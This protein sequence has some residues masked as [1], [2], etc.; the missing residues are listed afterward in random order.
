[1]KFGIT[2]GSGFLSSAIVK[3]LLKQNHTI[4]VFD[5][6]ERKDNSRLEP[7]LNQI[8]YQ[9]IDF[10]NR[11][12]VFDKLKKMDVIFHLYASAS[13]AAGFHDANI[14]F[15]GIVTTFNILE[16]MRVNN[17]KKI[18]FSSAPAIYGNTIEFP[19]REETGLLLPISFYGATKLASEGMISAF[20]HL[21]GIQSWIFRLGNVV[22]PDMTKGVIRDFIIKL[23]K[24]PRELEIL[25]SGNQM[26]DV[27]FI[28]DCV[29]GI[30]FAFEKSIEK[31][32]VFNISSGTTISV[33]KIAAIIQ[34]EMKLDNVK[35]IH[36]GKS[37]GWIG[38]PL[39]IHLDVT[40]INSLGWNAR[41]NSQQAVKMAVKGILKKMESSTT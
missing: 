22:G 33:N 26:K 17:I 14:D 38:D 32:N 35:L 40:K 9:K 21:Y 27:V 18:V 25:G 11:E 29:D 36:R 10:L 41:F 34:S 30:I 20:S 19:T 28:D 5:P 6:L 1:M 12:S 2:G 31:I 7:I 16:G 37:S 24:N 15:D 13:T 39:K 8:D 23:K 3:K 4:A